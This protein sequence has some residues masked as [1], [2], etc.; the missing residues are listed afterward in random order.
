MEQNSPVVDYVIARLGD[1]K[2]SNLLEGEA[3][4]SFHAGPVE[5]MELSNELGYDFIAYCGTQVIGTIHG[6][7]WKQEEANAPCSGCLRGLMVSAM[8]SITGGK[9][10]F[11]SMLGQQD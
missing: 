6:G 7:G 1:L 10:T 9:L 8:K 5:A 11:T 4:V 2:A 3:K